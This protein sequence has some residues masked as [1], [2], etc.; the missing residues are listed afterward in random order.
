MRA[1][2][3]KQ[4]LHATRLIIRNLST[5]L[6][7]AARRSSSADAADLHCWVDASGAPGGELEGGGTITC[8]AD[9]TMLTLA[10]AAA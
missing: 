5:L 4:I 3:A 8:T 1:G 7:S 10:E 9:D 6:R 2:V